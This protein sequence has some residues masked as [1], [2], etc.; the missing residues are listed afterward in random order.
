MI[1]D[2]QRASDLSP[3]ARNYSLSSIAIYCIS[4]AVTEGRIQQKLDSVTAI[5][6]SDG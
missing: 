2:V 3:S 6:L 5:C 1:L 4:Q